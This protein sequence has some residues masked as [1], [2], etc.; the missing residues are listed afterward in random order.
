MDWTAMSAITSSFSA[1]LDI[2]KSIGSVR[3]TALVGEKKK[4]L[5]NELFQLQNAFLTNAAVVK[6]LEEELMQV[7]RENDKLR[8]LMEDRGKYALVQLGHRQF[9]LRSIGSEDGNGAAPDGA[10]EPLHYICQPCF[11]KG[12]KS[13]LQGHYSMAVPNGLLC[14]ICKTIISEE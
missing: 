13:V 1:A 8:Q 6:S 9:A 4:A 12:V 10:N 7:R 11:A 2:A 14:P 3:D 5:T